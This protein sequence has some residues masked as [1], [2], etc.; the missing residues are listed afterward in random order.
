MQ[1]TLV[2]SMISP[3]VINT[4][5]QTINS[6]DAYEAPTRLQ[7]PEGTHLPTVNKCDVR[8]LLTYQKRTA[9]GP[10]EFLYRLWR[11]YSPHLHQ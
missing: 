6:D 7:I 11:D 10:D 2:S 3:D 9:L 5:F 8:N 1:G 4:Y